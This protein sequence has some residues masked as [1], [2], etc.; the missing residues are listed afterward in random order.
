MPKIAKAIPMEDDYQ[1]RSDA[2]TLTRAEEIRSDKN[3]HTAAKKHLA[4]K[5]KSVMAAADKSGVRYHAHNVVSRK[6]K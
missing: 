5:A 2:E 3:R 1:G 4:A 6:E